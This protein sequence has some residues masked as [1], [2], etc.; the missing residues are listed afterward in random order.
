[1]NDDPRHHVRSGFAA[2][3]EAPTS[4]DERPAPAAGTVSGGTADAA[5]AETTASP[6]GEASPADPAD[7]IPL[8]TWAPPPLPMRE[9][10]AGWAPAAEARPLDAPPET[11]DIGAAEP[12]E[13][14]PIEVPPVVDV[15]DLD[16][17][18]VRAAAAPAPIRSRLGA[19]VERFA[20]LLDQPGGAGLLFDS[21]RIDATDRAIRV[22]ELSAEGP[23]WFVG[24]LH[25]DLLALEAALALIRR[26]G[27]EAP[28][29]LVLLGD[30]FDDGGQPVEVLA[31]VFELMLKAPDRV[32][33]V[34][35]NHDEALG[36]NGSRFTADVTPSD[37][38]ELLNVHLDDRDLVAAGQLAVR[39]FAAAPRALFLPDGLLVAHGGIPLADLHAE[40][41]STGDWNAPAVLSDFVWTRAHA[42]ARRKLPNRTSRG[43]QFAREDFADFCRLAAELGRPVTHMVRGHDHV[44]ERFAVYDSY[45]PH[46]LL[47]IV[48][49]SRRLAR[50]AFGPF[51]RAP[52]VARWLPGALP[53]IYRL[54]IP[55][56][57]VRDLHRADLEAGATG[58]E[59]VP[60]MPEPVTPS[61]PPSPG[62]EESR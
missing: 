32:C 40:L 35:G 25:G 27:G 39:L 55:H 18:A 33:V 28:P 36:W 24:D 45:A 29:R 43:G 57:I 51:E 62:P 54:C 15:R 22:R 13:P 23:L 14:A 12:P 9:P 59:P 4:A 34:A 19:I 58:E 7:A 20:A 47:T 3:G 1:V 26:E 56:E 6:T 48:A 49:L 42:R 60:A 53:Q 8:S 30:L 10:T 44:E 31:R 38:S 52:C 50:E 37:F 46:A 21:D 5:A 61:A 17:D 41:R 16:W 11:D 2:R